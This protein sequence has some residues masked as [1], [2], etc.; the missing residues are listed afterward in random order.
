MKQQQFEHRY[1]AQWQAFDAWLGGL[2]AGKPNLRPPEEFP[3]LYRQLCQ[4]LSLARD[5]CY[6]PRLIDNLNQRVLAGHQYLYGVQPSGR[7]NPARYLL[8]DL[9]RCVRREWQAVLW[10]SLLFYGT[11]GVMLLLLNQYP[12]LVYSVVDAE[13]VA[14]VEAMYDPA[15]DALGPARDSE[16]NFLMFGFYIRHNISIAFQMLA[17]GVVF[18]LGAIF[19]LFFNGLYLGTIAGHLTQAGFGETFWPFVIGH[20]AF[21][22]TGLVFAGAIGLRLGFAVLAPGRW[23]R[24]EALRLTMQQ[25]LPML[26][27]VIGLLL[28]A[29]FVEAF[30]SASNHLSATLKLGVGSG[31]WLLVGAYF[32]CAGRG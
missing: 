32:C 22:L 8:Q 31:F 4:Q 25:L 7:F 26:Y 24:S 12:E 2:R 14:E 6:S 15:S 9:P 29:A 21:E 3:R 19:Y 17:G 20:G 5:R 27:G 23:P 30:W 10:A 13:T 16:S 18:G 28:T 11:F 1:A